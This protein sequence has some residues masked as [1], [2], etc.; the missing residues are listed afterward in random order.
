LV[1]LEVF[2]V[3]L[4]REHTGRVSSVHHLFMINLFRSMLYLDATRCKFRE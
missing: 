3:T 1:R 4:Q 2:M